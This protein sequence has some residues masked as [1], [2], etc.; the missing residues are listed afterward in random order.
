MLFMSSG[1][2]IVC[3]IPIGS[4]FLF[5]RFIVV[6]QC[7]FGFMYSKRTEQDQGPFQQGCLM[8]LA[9]PGLLAARPLLLLLLFGRHKP[10]LRQLGLG[11][12]NGSASRVLLILSSTALEGCLVLKG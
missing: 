6:V 2:G 5:N 8:F 11:H 9:I 4:V 1:A 3:L 10:C 7:L 12:V